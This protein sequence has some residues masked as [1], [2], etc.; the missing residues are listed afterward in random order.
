MDLSATHRDLSVVASMSQHR[1]HRGYRS[2]KVVAQYL[3]ANG[4]PYAEPTGAG[5]QGT[6][7]LGTVGI[8]WEVKARRGLVITEL[9]RQ[10]D[11]RAQDGLLGVG[12]IRPD[13]MGE[14]NVHLWPAVLTLA[15]LV[16]L[17]RAAG[18]GL[19]P[20]GDAS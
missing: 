15:D 6:D 9:V 10:L 14:T 18:Y 17:L 2:Q 4:F 20:A 1:K 11:A 13:G 8:D 12:V 7:I 3:E 5:R 19:P 16:A